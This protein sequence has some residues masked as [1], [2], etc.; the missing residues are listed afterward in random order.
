MIVG[1]KLNIKSKS[2]H[3][4]TNMTNINDFNSR[5]LNVERMAIDHDFT[6]YDVK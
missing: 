3:F 4:F 1:R 2:G 5:L 6:I